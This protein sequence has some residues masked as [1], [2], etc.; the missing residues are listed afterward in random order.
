MNTYKS[1][2]K[3]MLVGIMATALLSGC[4]NDTKKEVQQAEKAKEEAK[5]KE[6]KAKKE[7][8][9]KAR[10]ELEAKKV[11]VE[12]V[13]TC[14][15]NGKYCERGLLNIGTF[16]KLKAGMSPKEVAEAL[17]KNATDASRTTMQG[18]EVIEYTYNANKTTVKVAYKDG[19]L[20][21]AS[22]IDGKMEVT[23]IDGTGGQDETPAEGTNEALSAPAA[24]PKK[25]TPAPS[26]EKAPKKNAKSAIPNDY[27]G[28]G[29]DEYKQEAH[30]CTEILDKE[31]H[32]RHLQYQE[33]EYR[34]Q[35][36]AQQRE[37]EANR[38]YD[39]NG[40]VLLDD[41]TPALTE[42]DKARILRQEK[43]W[44]TPSGGIGDKWQDELKEMEEQEGAH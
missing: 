12:S 40:T 43:R 38:K 11:E 6:E 34:K 20:Y 24:A 17:R 32:Q 2:K 7:K 9:E 13:N 3:V 36:E 5:A 21:Y 4:G 35:K 15:A 41:G 44:N 1:I 28:H 22:H 31:A 27:C 26:T 19:G 29:H 30:G 10:A 39:E 14:D 8:E 18:V 42:E 16:E 23:T 37:E 33:E 25:D